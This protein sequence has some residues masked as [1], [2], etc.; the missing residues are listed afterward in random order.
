M[1][2][3]SLNLP[4]HWRVPALCLAVSIALHW[5]LLDAWFRAPTEFGLTAPATPLR[6]A[7]PNP[8]RRSESAGRE[9]ATPP[10]IEST[11]ARTAAARDGFDVAELAAARPD[12]ARPES[13]K[14]ASPASRS[15]ERTSRP[16]A[17]QSSTGP[18][19]LA[20]SLP[21][22]SPRA[23]LSS[24]APPSSAPETRPLH[25]DDRGIHTSEQY[26][27]ALLFEAG[28]LRANIAQSGAGRARVRLE[29]AAG[30]LLQSTRIT[31]SSGDPTLDDAATELLGRAHARVPVPAVL[32]QRP[33]EVEATVSFE[34]R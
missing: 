30:G 4:A 11:D 8:D 12:V 1:S 26:R 33:F 29:F 9:P 18:A 19:A 16:A 34:P 27:L 13:A 14:V 21:S 32:W 6:I 28:R 25:Q 10:P 7:M 17:S 20:P 23:A 15:T 22:A 31:A 24:S 3:A 5:I 2:S